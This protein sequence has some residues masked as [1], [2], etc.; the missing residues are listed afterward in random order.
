MSPENHNQTNLTSMPANGGGG[1]ISGLPDPQRLNHSETDPDLI[2]RLEGL[3]DLIF[4]AIEGDA[5][6]LE[7]AA[8]AWRKM[9]HDHGAEAM[10]ESRRQ[11]LRCA[12]TVW[13]ALRHEPNHPPHKVFAAIEI[14]SLLAGKAW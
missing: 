5:V 13:H 12:Q 1:P 14:I 6:A 2:A 7:N 10:E 4:A 11:Y 9:L 8:D 3:D